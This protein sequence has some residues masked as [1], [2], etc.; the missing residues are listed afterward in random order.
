MSQTT[1]KPYPDS[2]E[3]LRKK[4][5]ENLFA[6]AG[7]NYKAI[8]KELWEAL[9]WALSFDGYGED[10]PRQVGVSV[11]D[12]YREM[13]STAPPRPVKAPEAP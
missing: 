5:P 11:L 10:H 7:T 9:D 3:G 2:F 8:A 12:K 13:L 1:S 6:D 4:M